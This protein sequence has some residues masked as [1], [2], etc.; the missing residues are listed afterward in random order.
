MT[1]PRGHHFS[2][3]F[4][5]LFMLKN[6]EVRTMLVPWQEQ[7]KLFSWLL[8]NMEFQ[9][10]RVVRTK[11]KLCQLFCNHPNRLGL[12]VVFVFDCS[13]LSGYRRWICRRFYVVGTW[14]LGSSVYLQVTILNYCW[15]TAIDTLF[16]TKLL[17]FM[18]FLLHLMRKKSDGIV[19]IE[20][21]DS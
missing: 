2:F 12:I 16:N 21:P 14:W 8:N 3:W 13:F 1:R 19:L 20:A 7:R 6:L 5:R 15:L 10:K 9:C 18:W 11:T 17:W 4:Q